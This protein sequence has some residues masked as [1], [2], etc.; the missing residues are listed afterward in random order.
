MGWAVPT[1]TIILF[2]VTPPLSE[3]LTILSVS[4]SILGRG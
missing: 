2:M 4:S 1:S 3:R